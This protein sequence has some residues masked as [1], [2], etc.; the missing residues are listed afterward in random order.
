[1]LFGSW[2][3]AVYTCWWIH[4]MFH[5]NGYL[6]FV[7][8]M[9]DKVIETVYDAVYPEKIVLVPDQFHLAINKMREL[10]EQREYTEFCMVLVRLSVWYHLIYREFMPMFLYFLCNKSTTP[11]LV[12]RVFQF[13]NVC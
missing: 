2:S 4:S 9:V 6:L 7:T 11:T 13:M 10:Y 12:H 5:Q 1:M 8:Y 3:A